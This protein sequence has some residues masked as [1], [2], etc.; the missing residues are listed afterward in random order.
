M[1]F[2]SSVLINPGPEVCNGTL[3]ILPEPVSIWDVLPLAFCKM[4]KWPSDY[5]LWS[6]STTNSIGTSRVR[7]CLWLTTQHLLLIDNLV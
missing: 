2:V 4:T 6:F 1:M 7:C 5:G 3:E